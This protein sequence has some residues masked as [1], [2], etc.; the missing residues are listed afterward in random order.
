[1][2]SNLGAYQ[3]M[4]TVAKKVGGPVNLLLLTGT[5]GAMIYKGGE[6]VVKKCVRTINAHKAAKPVLEVKEHLYTVASGGRSNEGLE[7]AEG[8]RFRVLEADGD[9]ILIEK[10]GDKDNPYFVSAELLRRISN[11]KE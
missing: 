10:I 5:A 6:I 2:L 9:S 4:T 8:D 1:M 11:Y 7:F 3:W